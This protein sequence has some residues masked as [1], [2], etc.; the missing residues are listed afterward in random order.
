MMKLYQQA[1]VPV[2]EKEGKGT[3]IRPMFQRESWMF[4]KRSWCI[5]EL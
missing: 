4:Q 2:K 3:S 1:S 5:A